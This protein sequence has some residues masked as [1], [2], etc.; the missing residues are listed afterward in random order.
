[1]RRSQNDSGRAL[2]YGIADALHTLTHAT[3]LRDENFERVKEC[4]ERCTDYERNTIELASRKIILFL[5]DNDP[6]LAFPDNHI[7]IQS[8]QA[9]RLGD[10]RDIIIHDE[11][12]S[13]EIGLSS[14]NRHYAVKHSRLSQKIDFGKIWFG[15]PCSPQ[16]FVSTAPIFQDLLERKR[17]GELWRNISDKTQRYYL[18]L[19]DIFS[20]EMLSLI[21]KDPNQVAK[22]FLKYLLGIQDYYKVIK[23]NGDVTAISF[24][25]NG[26]LKWG[27]RL[28]L[29][30]RVIE[31]ASKSDNLTTIEITFD[32]GWQLSFR[33][34]NASS[35][36]E[37]SLKFD[38][39]II[40]WPQAVSRHVL[41][42]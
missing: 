26:S 40:G 12:Q 36:V 23:E 38:I 28:P 1:M 11:T 39:N 31:I 37:P 41:H 27:N 42:Y 30:T 21:K 25:I 7:R 20:N 17:R 14:K 10:V 22:G 34:H 9:G 4:F 19:L 5:I 2:E 32:H 24:N 16:Y 29:P 15:V 13:Y 3:L 35:R 8:D 33:I 18:P 6:R